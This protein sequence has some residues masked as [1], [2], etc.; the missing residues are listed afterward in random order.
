MISGGK[1]AENMKTKA[2]TWLG[3]DIGVWFKNLQH[4]LYVSDIKIDFN[5]TMCDQGLFQTERCQRW[6]AQCL[7]SVGRLMLC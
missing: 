2:G 6:S 3:Q 5:V 1:I 4:E 7:I